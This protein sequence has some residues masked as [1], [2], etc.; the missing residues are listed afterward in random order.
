MSGGERDDRA[1]DFMDAARDHMAAG[2]LE[3]AAE[4][5][6]RARIYDTHPDSNSDLL[7]LE[8]ELRHRRGH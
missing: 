5:L 6:R 1:K 4:D 8:E 3:A 2:N 7:A